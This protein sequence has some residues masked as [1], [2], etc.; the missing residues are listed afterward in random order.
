M[1]GVPTW[2]STVQVALTWV[3]SFMLHFV[4]PGSNPGPGNKVFFTLPVVRKSRKAGGPAGLIGLPPISYP[5]QRKMG[6]SSRDSSSSKA[7]GNYDDT[8]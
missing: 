8:I 5:K 2:V 7:T 6:I 3:V 1:C 4:F